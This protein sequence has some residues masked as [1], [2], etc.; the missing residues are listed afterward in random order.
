MSFT[1]GRFT[2]PSEPTSVDIDGNTVTFGFHVIPAAATVAA[3]Q[4]L[5]QQM[6]GLVENRD[7][8]VVPIVWS[9]DDSFDGFYRVVGVQAPSD[10]M[11]INA[12]RT[13]N[14]SVTLERLTDYANPTFEVTVQSVVRTNGHGI[15]TPSTVVAYAPDETFDPGPDLTS[16]SEWS[17]PPDFTFS[18]TATARAYRIA[19]P[20]S[21]TAWRYS[22]A[23]VDYYGGACLLEV[24]YSDGNWYPV[25]G[26]QVPYAL[27]WR[28][29]N[30]LVR[31]TAAPSTTAADGTF[32]VY[33]SGSGWESIGVEHSDGVRL[34]RAPNLDDA[35]PL[36]ILR[37]SPEQVSVKIQAG[38]RFVVWTLQRG[39]HVALGAWGARVAQQWG[40][41]MSSA[42][43]GTN[44]T[45]G[46]R[47][48][49]ND[50]NGNRVVFAM[51]AA[52]TTDTGVTS[53]VNT[54]T[55]TSG[56]F[57]LGIELGGSSAAAGNQAAN[58]VD[59]YFGAVSWRQRV[60]NR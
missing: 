60:V 39:A 55:A 13:M 19:A 12:G 42:V 48:T 15:S 22:A 10:Q 27:D 24:K 30:G 37:N 35:Q 7:E 29:S 3:L 56:N 51:A 46:I 45:G 40:L 41:A 31:L 49:S 34:G 38:E 50:A 16:A 17:R 47:V 44:V 18:V 20:L 1:I 8:E 5:R 36:Q 32:E 11:M 43:G 6:L 21:L 53:I 28:I 14:C 33:A 57:G 23:P 58:I 9:A 26:R 25:T 52:H 54:S 59:Q 2:A 4:P